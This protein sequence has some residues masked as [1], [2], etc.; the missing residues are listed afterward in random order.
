MRH[1]DP[2]ADPEPLIRRVYAFVAYRVGDG[3]EAEDITSET[4]ARALRGRDSFD[5]S[6]GTAIGWLFGIARRCLAEAVEA[7]MLTVAQPVE[8]PGHHDLEERAVSRI[9]LAEAVAKL[10]EREQELVALR[11]GADLTAKR[12]GEILGMQPNAVEVALHRALARLR[13]TLSPSEAPAR[14]PKP[15][16]RSISVEP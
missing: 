8:E 11:Y 3:H 1:R 2:L 5:P 4:F 15:T 6:R 16:S 12:I 14:A 13:E 10:E 7:R 9:T